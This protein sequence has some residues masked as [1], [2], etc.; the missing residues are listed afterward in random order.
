MALFKL[1]H[2]TEAVHVHIL[3]NCMSD[4]IEHFQLHAGYCVYVP[5]S[6]KL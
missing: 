2:I 1:Q 3:V 5:G 6:T 4:H